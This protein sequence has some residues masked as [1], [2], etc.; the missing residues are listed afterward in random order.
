M[1]AYRLAMDARQIVPAELQRL[2]NT[3]GHDGRRPPRVKHM[4]KR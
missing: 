1:A 2:A 4:E 3:G